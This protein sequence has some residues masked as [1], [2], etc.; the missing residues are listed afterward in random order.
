MKG[1]TSSLPQMTLK[2]PLL[3][4]DTQI[5]G[6]VPI[7]MKVKGTFSGTALEGVH[8]TGPNL[9]SAPVSVH[10]SV[11]TENFSTLCPFMPLFLLTGS[12]SLLPLSCIFL[13]LLRTQLKSHFCK[14]FPEPFLPL[15]SHAQ[16]G[17]VTSFVLSCFV[18]VPQQR[19]LHP[20]GREHV[21]ALLT[22]SPPDWGLPEGRPMSHSPPFP[23][24]WLSAGQ[25]HR[26]QEVNEPENKT[27]ALSESS[28]YSLT[29]RK[30]LPATSGQTLKTETTEP[31]FIVIC[32]LAGW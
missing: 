28:C 9:P 12:P 6:G 23:G 24:E 20:V 4:W 13:G 19:T 31:T 1:S 32:L 21:G 16:P 30:C 8:T 29:T 18:H 5:T 10:F 27:Q 17:I 2:R 14:G 26:R 3:P 22:L 25:A 15:P 11:Y 7:S